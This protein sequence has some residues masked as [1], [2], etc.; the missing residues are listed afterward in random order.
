MDSV[1]VL[2][3]HHPTIIMM[4]LQED[5]SKKN[6]DKTYIKL[7]SKQYWWLQWILGKTITQV[8]KYFIMNTSWVL[9]VPIIQ[10]IIKY[11]HL[12]K[13]DTSINLALHNK[14]SFSIAQTP[15]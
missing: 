15:I 10:Y 5:R 2:E 8:L 6:K 11:V 1:M 13:D 7:T 9:N 3:L 12:F 14:H 4:W